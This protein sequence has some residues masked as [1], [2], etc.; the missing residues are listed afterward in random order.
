MVEGFDCNIIVGS[1]NYL[2]KIYFVVVD[3]F[4]LSWSIGVYRNY[5]QHNYTRMI[6]RDMTKQTM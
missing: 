5:I 6:K 1:L 2:A 4:F 3:V